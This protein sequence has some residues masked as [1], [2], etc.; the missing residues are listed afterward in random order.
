MFF[1]GNSMGKYILLATVISLN[2]E[3]FPL[4]STGSIFTTND[5]TYLVLISSIILSYKKLLA[6][7]N[8]DDHI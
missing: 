8:S 5:T 6:V 1:S 4:K 3:T 2:L 7:Q